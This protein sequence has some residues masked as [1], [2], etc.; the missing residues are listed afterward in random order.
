MSERLKFHAEQSDNIDMKTLILA[1]LSASNV[2]LAE[3]WF[4]ENEAGK[5]EGNTIQACGIGEM[6]DEGAARHFALLDARREFETIC[7]MSEDCSNKPVSVEPLRTSCKPFNGHWKCY[8]LIV[9]TI[10]TE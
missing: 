9:V 5:R 4:C 7:A 8:R 3:G 2:A 1:L 10:R 6:M